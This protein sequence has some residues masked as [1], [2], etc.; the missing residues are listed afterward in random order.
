MQAAEKREG[1]HSV[2]ACLPCVLCVLCVL[3]VKAFHM[4][5]SD[6]PSKTQRKK[7]VHELQALGEE[8]VELSEER[9]ASLNLPERLRE[10][11]M[12]ARRITAHEARRRQL[13]Y[14]GKIMRTVDPEPLRA[15]LDGWRGQAAR[16]TAGH[17]R[18]EAWRERL[19][20]DDAALDE[21]A[22]EYPAAD[23]AHLSSL[24]SSALRE[25]SAAQPPRSYRALF[26]AL[27][28]LIEGYTSA[29]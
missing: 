10:A 8:L 14:I 24:V 19:L 1:Y 21:L 22:A 6:K 29:P 18:A 15:A 23:V 12:E 11:V 7:A 16:L 2:K 27:R 26:Q 5:E 20:A 9:L 13:Q 4:S 25:R 17:K 28:A 3:R